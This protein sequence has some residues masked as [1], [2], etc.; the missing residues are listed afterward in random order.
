MNKN[1]QY[2][3]SAGTT[4]EV[5]VNTVKEVAELIG[6]D[7]VKKADIESGKY[8]CVTVMYPTGSVTLS[9]VTTPLHDPLNRYEDA[10]AED[11]GEEDTAVDGMQEDTMEEVED[12]EDMEE[13][14]DTIEDAEEDTDTVEDEIEDTED[15]TDD[16]D[17]DNNSDN[18]KKPS[19]EEL[20]ARMKELNKKKAEQ[21]DTTKK[22]GKVA[23]I[24][25]DVDKDG[26]PEV[27]TFP[28]EKSLSKAVKE[29][30]D[31]QIAEW[32]TLEG[33]KYNPC[34]THEG[35]NRMR[36]IM[37]IKELH[38]PKQKS[39]SKK[40][41][42]KYADYSTEDL[43]ALCLDNDI[44]VPDPKGDMRILRMYSIMALRKAGLIE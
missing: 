3:I 16:E 1:V 37:A 40:S 36:M 38:F 11:M 42:S 18:G 35:I 43:V 8:P 20:M 31:D 4:E 17:E 33:L 12:A 5:V 23:K 22:S 27:G 15:T 28:D 24:K 2:V 19:M 26:F 44:D 39:G 7:K 41:K 21:K 29:L 34:E 25:I 9:G 13:A 30:S 14:T 6:V 32:I 10:T